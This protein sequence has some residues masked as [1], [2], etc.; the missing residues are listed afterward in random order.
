MLNSGTSQRNIKIP[1]RYAD[2]V[3][4]V[5]SNINNK[6]K[7]NNVIQTY[8]R[9]IREC[10]ARSEEDDIVNDLENVNVDYTQDNIRNED[11]EQNKVNEEMIDQ[12]VKNVSVENESGI[13]NGSDGSTQKHK[14]NFKH[15][16]GISAIAS[17]VGKP[18]IMDQVTANMCHSR[19][20]RIGFARVLVEIDAEKGYTDKI[21][22]IYMDD[23]KNVKRRKF[24]D[25]EYAWKPL[26]KHQEQDRQKE[27]GKQNVHE[28]FANWNGRSN[29][30]F[31][32]SRMRNNGIRNMQG[33]EGNVN[34]KSYDNNIKMMYR[35]K[36]KCN[37]VDVEN[38]N[39]KP[40]ENCS[41]ENAKDSDGSKKESSPKQNMW[42][43]DK[44]NMESLK[45]SANKFA[46]LQDNDNE[47]I[48][49]DPSFDK[50]LIVD[51]LLKRKQQP[52][53]NDTKKCTYDMINCFKHQWEALKRNGN[54]SDD[55]EDVIEVNDM[56]I[57][58]L[59]A[60]EINVWNIRGMSKAIKQNEV[61][62][63]INNKRLNMCAVLETHLKAKNINKICDKVFSQ[64]DWISNAKYS[65]TCCRIFIGWDP[66]VVRVMIIH[67]SKQS[68]LCEVEN[69]ANKEKIV[70]SFVYAANTC[71]ERRDLW[72]DLSIH[73]ILADNKPWLLMGDFNVTLKPEEHSTW[74]SVMTNDMQE[75][76]DLVNN[77]EVDDICSSGFFY[78]W[79]KSLRNPNNSILKKLDRV[80][81]IEAFMKEN[82]YAHGVFL[83]YM[84]SG[85][86]P[87]V[88]CLSDKLPKQQAKIK[89][90][91]DG[92]KN[93]A[94]FHRE[95]KP[96]QHLNY[97]G[98]IIK[99]KLD[100]EEACNM[101]V[102]V[103]D[104]EIKADIFDIDNNK[105]TGPDEFSSCFFKKAW[106]F[107]GQDV[108]NAIKE[109][110]YNGKLLGEVNASLI[111]LVP[112][113]HVP[114]KVSDFRLIV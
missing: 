25:V 39:K 69:V 95:A 74:S 113:C 73:K 60:D 70:S 9:E 67:E 92:D 93:T 59:V 97:V 66:M 4:E 33:Q 76:H 85:H 105:V 86:S 47:T 108:C 38:V 94:Y 20:G 14:S 18:V 37:N 29:K 110:L 101:I 109:F 63:L 43:I 21:E 27:N 12:G 34:K 31:G 79:T 55:E 68:I 45:R 5:N 56:A 2:C 11:S 62:K 96:V 104:K 54:D 51:I 36:E 83:P 72:R 106:K 107:I 112:K 30:E 26:D 102:D 87:A 90:F 23:G 91:S 46:V 40:E 64:W 111:V 24:V 42:R 100:M 16:D 49:N 78:T 35:P 13:N 3:L 71:A 41:N 50:R 84:V 17:R 81:I 98:E 88:L 82:G 48:W 89:W 77:I 19:V 75:F 7:S 10:L 61:I 80:M 22:I 103:T 65:P 52:T 114:L 57:S 15:E 32:F 1:S 6:K 8:L 44:G 28:G 53:L 99:T 58:N